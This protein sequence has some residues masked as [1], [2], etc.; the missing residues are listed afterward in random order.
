MIQLC[1]TFVS[2]PERLNALLACL[3]ENDLACNY[4]KVAAGFIVNI[5][6][7]RAGHGSQDSGR[8]EL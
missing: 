8:H 4:Y 1:R 2:D 5:Y 6:S 7:I 3:T